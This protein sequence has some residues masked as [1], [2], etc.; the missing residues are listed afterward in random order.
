MSNERERKSADDELVPLL[1]RFLFSEGVG[2]AH[3]DGFLYLQIL[4]LAQL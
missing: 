2:S 1:L 4:F 3:A